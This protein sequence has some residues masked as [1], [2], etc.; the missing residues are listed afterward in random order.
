MPLLERDQIESLQW[1]YE[2][3]FAGAPWV[4]ASRS[5]QAVVLL[6]AS[7]WVVFR[8]A[9]LTPASLT[10][11][12]NNGTPPMSPALTAGVDIA[13]LDFAFIGLDDSIPSGQQ[14]WKVTNAD[15]QPHLMTI[16][17]LPDGTTQA[18]FMDSPSAM[19]TGTPVADAIGPEHMLHIG[20]CSTLSTGQ[21]LYLALDLAV[22]TYG[23]VCFFPDAQTGAPHV[24]MEMAQVFMAG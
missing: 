22:A 23:A 4:P 15:P 7:E 18:R 13:M 1:I 10:V 3:A 14:I 11:T 16:S 19:M 2:T 17:E 20:G 12:E 8:S 9:P 6:T 5:A 21:S 24:M